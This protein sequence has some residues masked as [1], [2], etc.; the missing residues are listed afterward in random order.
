MK[1]R[2]AVR[3]P[4]E[5]GHFAPGDIWGSG[6]YMSPPGSDAPQHGLGSW[7]LFGDAEYEDED[8]GVSTPPPSRPVVPQPTQRSFSIYST[9]PRKAIS[10]EDF[11]PQR[12]ITC[13]LSE[14]AEIL[15]TIKG[16]DGVVQLIRDEEGGLLA[17]KTGAG[18]SAEYRTLAA[19]SSPYVVKAGQLDGVTD[20]HMV[21]AAA[22]NDLDRYLG[23]VSAFLNGEANPQLKLFF[24][25][26]MTGMVLDGIKAV[27]T[28]HNQ[29]ICDVKP[30]NVLV[31]NHGTLAIADLG[32]MRKPGDK[33]KEGYTP[34]YAPPE[35][36]SESIKDDIN[37]N[38]IKIGF[39]SDVWSFGAM[40][41]KAVFGE[42]YFRGIA[43]VRD[44]NDPLAFG[45]VFTLPNMQ[46]L[47]HQIDAKIDGLPEVLRPH[48]NVFVKGCLTVN[49]DDRPKISEMQARVSAALVAFKD[50]ELLA[51]CKAVWSGFTA[52][53]LRT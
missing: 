15:E 49:P 17:K 30:M 37:M 53:L 8:N 32:S 42:L 40:M 33:I 29:V 36:F 16:G 3:F 2:V 48:V 4:I 20:D 19:L 43:D 6:G 18:I 28:V 24:L 34:S 7:S 1:K 9:P 25:L 27:H 52:D 35:F 31:F 13:R 51:Q 39:Y 23:R 22:H 12:A 11:T 5:D 47:H 50:P 38:D 10:K 45:G 41:Y 44:I 26:N 14:N 21:M 46:K